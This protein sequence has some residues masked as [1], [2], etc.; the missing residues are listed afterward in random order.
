MLLEWDHFVSPIMN[1]AL[2]VCKGLVYTCGS[3][4]MINKV[5][6]LLLKTFSLAWKKHWPYDSWD[7][8]QEVKVML[9]RRFADPSKTSRHLSWLM[10]MGLLFPVPSRLFLSS[11]SA[12]GLIWVYVSEDLVHAKKLLKL[13][14]NHLMPEFARN[15]MFQCFFLVILVLF[16]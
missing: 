7:I 13:I 9:R 12:H 15:P 16:T 1:V 11:V 8:H 14:Y 5:L 10:H 2:S 4:K 6:F 3:R